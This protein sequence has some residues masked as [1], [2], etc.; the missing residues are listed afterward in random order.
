MK[1]AIL[2]EKEK[3]LKNQWTHDWFRIAFRRPFIPFTVCHCDGSHLQ[4][5]ANVKSNYY[6]MFAINY[7]FGNL[8]VAA[9]SIPISMSGHMSVS[10]DISERKNLNMDAKTTRLIKILKHMS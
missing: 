2:Q 10:A 9:T 1:R 5:P 6:T 8:P 7:F 4:C 3:W